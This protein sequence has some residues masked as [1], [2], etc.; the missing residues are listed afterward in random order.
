MSQ[1][2]GV[3]RGALQVLGQDRTCSGKP[4]GL[5]ETHILQQATSMSSPKSFLYGYMEW[6]G[7]YKTSQDTERGGALRLPAIYRSPSSS[8]VLSQTAFLLAFSL[9]LTEE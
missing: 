9:V 7:S 1:G 6:E 2:L 4:A 8:S 5:W 3:G